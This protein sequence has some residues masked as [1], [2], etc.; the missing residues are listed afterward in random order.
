MAAP[1][2]RLFGR[3]LR[4]RLV[5]IFALVLVPPVLIAWGKAG[6][7]Y[8]QE[9]D[10]LERILL[11]R[12]KLAANARSSVIQ[13]ARDLLGTLAELDEIGGKSPER[14][15][16]SL[17]S[18]L[19][20]NAEYQSLLILDETGRILCSNLPF[21]SSLQFADRDWF[22]AP[23]EGRPFFVSEP[24]Y[25]R[26]TR[27]T[28]VVASVP[29]LARSGAVIG[30]VAAGISWGRLIERPGDTAERN[31]QS[32]LAFV[33][34]QGLVLPPTG[35]DTASLDDVKTDL[36][37]VLA[38]EGLAALPAE[39]SLLTGRK[40]IWAIVPLAPGVIYLAIGQPLEQLNQQLNLK[41]LIG[42]ALP[43]LIWVAAVGT[44][45]TTANRLIVHWVLRVREL[46]AAIA[47]GRSVDLDRR[48]GE[49]P[50]EIQELA[51]SLTRMMETIQARNAEL[52]EAVDHRET[53]IR[54]IHHRVKNNLQIIASLVNLQM[55][56]VRDDRARQAMMTVRSRV[57]ALALI[58]RSLY[59]T[60][61]LQRIELN[62]F[63]RALMDQVAEF[64]D[65][66][67]RNI[68][69]SVEVPP[70]SVPAETAVTLALLVTEALSNAFK[71][72]FPVEGGGVVRIRMIVDEGKPPVLIISDDGVGG[73]Q[74]GPLDEAEE[75]R[76]GNLG[77]QLM[78]GYARQLG[79][80]LTVNSDKG[81]TIRIELPD[82][83]RLRA[84][85]ANFSPAAGAGVPRAPLDGSA[86]S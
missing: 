11:Q 21:D 64:L 16:A 66:K 43:A 40:R 68:E 84:G 79:G 48:L 1:L 75:D 61:E 20:R 6:Y 80:T 31:D 83:F 27:T 41:L 10:G 47:A 49:A 62:S 81:T 4:A 56:G 32:I 46:G 51:A 50:Q 73:S 70:V 13:G 28:V 14:C 59:E 42:L 9:R 8:V 36:G 17:R 24:I 60:D 55:R 58:H 71:H 69:V 54:E 78:L 12:A 86:R 67:R 74:G 76:E 65:A 7:D 2:S 29:L 18:A 63:L 34:R 23:L 15:N 19:A 57:N 26:L 22:R 30:V 85:V 44:A 72:A 33:N 77:H 45:W 82:L 52:R 25:S 37:D 38:P 35:A 3:S 39:G 53:L 5:L